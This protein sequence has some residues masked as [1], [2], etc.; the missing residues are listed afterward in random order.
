MS[1]TRHH[2][3][4]FF[5]FFFFFVRRIVR[6]RLLCV[7]IATHLKRRENFCRPAIFHPTQMAASLGQK[8]PRLH[9]QQMP[10]CRPSNA[11]RTFFNIES[12]LGKPV[13]RF[14]VSQE[15][16]ARY[17]G[18]LSTPNGLAMFGMWLRDEIERAL[19]QSKTDPV[20]GFNVNEWPHLFNSPLHVFMEHPREDK[21]TILLQEYNNSSTDSGLWAEWL[22]QG[23]SPVLRVMPYYRGSE[24]MRTFHAT[25]FIVLLMLHCG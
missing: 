2:R 19:N 3:L 17:V 23:K 14:G 5:F 20:Y 9:E 16:L 1:A 25:S 21:G 10:V 11:N 6:R 4:F 24:L 13:G 8:R 12:L 7:N 22:L 15:D 18:Y